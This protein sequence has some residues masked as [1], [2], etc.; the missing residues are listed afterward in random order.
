VT[1]PGSTKWARGIHLR[2]TTLGHLAQ[3]YGGVVPQ[4]SAHS[5]VTRLSPPEAAAEG[6]LVPLLVPRLIANAAE[7]VARGAS[8]LVLADVAKHPRA[9]PLG[10]WVHPYA[11]WAMARVLEEWALVSQEPS[12]LG[13]DVLLGANVELGPRVLLG[14]RVTIG[15]SSVIGGV[16][17]GWA[18]GPDGHA[19]RVPHLG[20]VVV[21]DDVTVGPLCTIDA[22]VLSPTI[23]RR[24]AHLDA[25]VHVAHNCE[26]GEGTFVAAQSGLAGSVK[27]GRGV[28]VGGQVGI[29]DH[30]TVGD[31]ARIA[32]KSGVIGDVPTGAT[33]AGYPAVLHARWLRGLGELYRSVKKRR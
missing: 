26:V 14:D 4:A 29:A 11:A 22:G 7:A 21:E 24:G 12:L 2:E 3:A 16:G 32:A 23:I 27:V 19:T 1:G 28:L 8:L 18:I 5:R 20:G 13:R 25:Q 10:G 30:V 17:F 6:D 15:A 31:G 33:V 9:R